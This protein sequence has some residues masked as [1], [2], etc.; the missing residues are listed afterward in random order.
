M[1]LKTEGLKRMPVIVI[2]SNGPWYGMSEEEIEDRKE[3]IRW[4]INKDIEVLLQ[5]PIPPRDNDFW[6]SSYQDFLE[7][8]FNTY[9]YQKD[10]RPF[11]KYGYRIRKILEEVKDLAIMHSSI[12]QPEGRAN[13]L[14]RYESLVENEF[15]NRLVSL[16]E[17]YNTS[18]DEERRLLARRKIAELSRRIL[19]CEKIW[20]QYAYWE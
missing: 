12:S 20:K 13:T 14:R 6:F 10:Q 1:W 11:D 19:Q 18:A 3:F 9:D 5:I 15:R 7:S 17:R 8:A 16:A 2:R 4:Y